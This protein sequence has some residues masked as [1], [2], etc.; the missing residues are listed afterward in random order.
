MRTDVEISRNAETTEAF[1]IYFDE[2]KSGAQMIIL[3]DDMK[4]G[5]PI[6]IVED[7]PAKTKKN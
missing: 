6:T 1:T 7:A 5:L 2:I 4:V 3:W